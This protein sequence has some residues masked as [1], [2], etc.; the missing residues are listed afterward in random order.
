MS[1]AGVTRTHPIRVRHYY[2][3]SKTCSRVFPETVLGL[4]DQDSGLVVSQGNSM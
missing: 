2:S 1:G 4:P 3:S